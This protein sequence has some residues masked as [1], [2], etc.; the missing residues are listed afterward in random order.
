MAAQADRQNEDWQKAEDM[1][2]GKEPI[3]VCFIER[4]SRIH[5]VWS[6]SDA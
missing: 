2:A 6:L 4:N 3:E 1:G 5:V